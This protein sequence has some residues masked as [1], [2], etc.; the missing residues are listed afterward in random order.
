LH[1]REGDRT[2]RGRA[3]RD[4]RRRFRSP[5]RIRGWAAPRVALPAG[6]D[7][8][9]LWPAGFVGSITHSSGEA[10]A[11]A[12]RRTRFAS[13]GVDLEAIVSVPLWLADRVATPMERRW[14]GA[15]KDAGLRLA[16]VF[17]AKEAWQKAQ[18]PL[19]GRIFDFREVDVRFDLDV[20]VF[21][22]ESREC[23]ADLRAPNRGRCGHDDR[24][25]A[26]LVAANT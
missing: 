5:R 26:T 24:R 1:R 4:R 20:G 15:K 2:V 8:A 22:I 23:M 14:I 6:P 7:R 25:V 12:A 16:L 18:F 21:E 19:S 13:L 11:V 10:V 3:C 9:P 17:S